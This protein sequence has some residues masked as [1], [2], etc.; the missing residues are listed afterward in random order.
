MD[1]KKLSVIP[2]SEVSSIVGAVVVGKLPP[3][4]QIEICVHLRHKPSSPGFPTLEE[5]TATPL[6][7]R[8]YLSHEEF[9]R[10]HGADPADVEKI[11]AFGREHGIQVGEVELEHR[12]VHLKGT[13]KAMNTAFGVSLFMYKLGEKVFRAHPGPVH[14]P[15]EL[16][17]IVVG[18]FG[19][20]NPEIARPHEENSEQQ[21]PSKIEMHSEVDTSYFTG[22]HL[23]KLYNFPS[24]VT[25]KG[26][27]IGI[28]ALGG[29][30]KIDCL[31]EYF[32]KYVGLP[33]PNII[34]VNVAGGHN[35]PGKNYGFDI[36]TC[37]DI[38]LAGAVAPGADTVVYFAPDANYFGFFK[39]LYT[40]I[41]DKEHK[42]TIISISWGIKEGLK[43]ERT[44]KDDNFIK[45]MNQLLVEAASLGIT[46]CAS[47]GDNGSSDIYKDP[48]SDMYAHVDFPGSSPWVL[49]CGGTRIKVEGNAIKSEVVWN[50]EKD[51][52][53]SGGGVSA[54]F[55]CPPYQKKAGIFPKSVNQ[56][57]GVGRGVPDVAGN[58]VDFLIKTN[59]KPIENISGTSGVAP[60]WAGLIALLNQKLNTRLGFIN[61]TLYEI[62]D[63][64]VFRD[65]T[66]GNNQ[67]YSWVPGYSAGP[68]WD[69]CTGL[70]T[71]HG[72][73]LYEV[74][75]KMLQKG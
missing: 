33:M 32:K 70:G 71:P 11:K 10:L 35:N 69:A 30:Y 24:D 61:P 9:Q 64:G 29:G 20:S 18:V 14:I 28:I 67:V 57:V 40:A 47:S 45:L 74:L 23:A 13:V 21:E 58:A 25:G 43:D 15:E 3:K 31:R 63:S 72:K 17:D 66:Q 42:N 16:T 53:A 75:Y 5:F 65:I 37:G 27:S 19:L 55:S 4:E 73:K 8:K 34:D 59:E 50:D 38:E 7:Q 1:I 6:H 41:Q 68:G 52:R 26:Q 62:R 49:G 12:C 54:Y 56:N 48:K 36:E 2:G 51:N 22:S 39:A 46:V 60:L 44:K